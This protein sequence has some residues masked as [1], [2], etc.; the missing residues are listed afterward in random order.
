MGGMPPVTNYELRAHK[1]YNKN[2]DYYDELEKDMQSR[3]HF[4][5]FNTNNFGPGAHAT[6]PAHPAYVPRTHS[7]QASYESDTERQP[8]PAKTNKPDSYAIQAYLNA[9]EEAN[10]RNMPPPPPGPPPPAAV[11]G[12]SLQVRSSG[13]AHDSYNPLGSHSR[14]SSIGSRGPSPDRRPL[15]SQEYHQQATHQSFLPPPPPPQEQQQKQQ[16]QFSIPPPPP[17]APKVPA[18]SMPSLPKLRVPKKYAPP[19]ITVQDATPVEGASSSGDL[20]QAQGHNGGEVSTGRK[21][22]DPLVEHPP[23]F[24]HDGFD[25]RRKEPPAPLS[26]SRSG[27]TERRPQ[28]VMQEIELKTG[29]GAVFG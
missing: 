27:S 9:S 15:L 6:L 1:S 24:Q 26:V 8:R 13:L 5:G 3:H 4:Y 16:T 25:K 7:R 23:R 12:S 28:W 18:L 22:S 14:D 20:G 2:A 19:V 17:R 10:A 21:I 29:K 11:R